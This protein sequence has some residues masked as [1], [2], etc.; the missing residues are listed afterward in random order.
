[1]YEMLTGRL[2]FM[3]DGE[4]PLLQAIIRQEPPP[5]ESLRTGV[6]APL[7][8]IASKCLRKRPDERY[9][10][11]ADLIADLRSVRRALT[12]ATVSTL[13]G[14][15][16]FS[17]VRR[18]FRPAIAL[19]VGAAMVALLLLAVV[20]AARNLVRSVLNLQAVPNQQHMAVLPFTNVGDDPANRA[21]CD[22]LTEIMTSNLTQFER[23]QGALWVVPAT[24]VRSRDIKSA[25][26]ARKVF[27]VNL[28]F[29]GGVQRQGN[30]LR[31]ALNLV[32]TENLRQLRSR[33]IEGTLADL[34]SLEDRVLAATAEMLEVQIKPVEKSE[35]TAGGTTLGAAY[36]LY[37]QARGALGSYQGERDPQRA[38][39]L[40]QRAIAL[41]PTFALAHAGLANAYLELFWWKKDPHL[42]DEAVGSARR[43]VELNDRLGEVHVTLGEIY[44]TTGKYEVSVREYQR[45]LEIDPK[46]SGALSGLAKAFAALGKP[47]DAEETYKRAIALKPDDWLTYNRLGAFYVT[48]GRYEDAEKQ[49]KKVIALT[50]ENFWGYNNLAVL[51]YTLGRYAEARAMFERASSIRP[52]PMLFS[53]LGTLAFIQRDWH[54]AVTNFEQACK[55]DEK[56]YVPRGNLGIAYHWLGGHEPQSREALTKAIAL[57]EQQLSVN[58]RDTA[59]LA[60]LAGY[61]A[62]LGEKDKA[63]SYIRMVEADA[64]KSPDL[65]IQIAD[66]FTD[67]GQPDTAIVWIGVGLDLGFPTVQLSN[68]PALDGLLKDPRVQELLSAH[69]ATTQQPGK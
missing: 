13:P 12:S 41:D 29:T 44:R 35:I 55:G 54:G 17:S 39:E 31:L 47:E 20:P 28:V 42:V 67:L 34:S 45:A 53:N 46:N 19:P 64:H 24:E 37:V 32:D 63:L 6:P 4:Q 25:S 3:A 36:D 26:D 23:F 8:A 10:R 7:A 33:V 9:Q 48:H 58:P 43:A 38:V 1:M 40:F 57:A 16:P 15:P 2:P 52:S 27:N 14:A 22:G 61:H 65:A 30:R 50:P 21:F 56:D 68:M 60:D 59:V 66:V 11:A 51:Y 62:L 18:R 5:L 49:H 69:R